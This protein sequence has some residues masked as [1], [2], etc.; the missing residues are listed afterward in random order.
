VTADHSHVFTM[1]GYPLRKASELPYAVVS[2]PNEYVSSPHNNLFDVVYDV[3]NEGNIV[4]STDSNGVPYTILGYHNGP[5]YRGKP[6]VDPAVDPFLGLSG[7]AGAGPNDSTYLQESAVPLG[8]ETHAGEDVALYAIGPR[9]EMVRGTVKNS[10]VFTVMKT[11]L[12]L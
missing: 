11:A 9:A 10:F 12:G 2:A 5:G 7:A 4:K 6:R 3:D 8:S 1:A